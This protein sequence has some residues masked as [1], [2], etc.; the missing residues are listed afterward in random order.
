MTGTTREMTAGQPPLSEQW[1]VMLPANRHDFVLE[2]PPH[3]LA[4]SFTQ[5]FVWF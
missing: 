5:L 3:T 2:E 1:L 4:Q